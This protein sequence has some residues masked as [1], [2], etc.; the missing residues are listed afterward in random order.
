MYIGEEAA[1]SVLFAEGGR[2]SRDGLGGERRRKREPV[3]NE[4][5]KR[6]RKIFARGIA[7]FAPPIHTPGLELRC[8]EGGRNISVRGSVREGPKMQVARL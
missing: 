8:G 3:A 6:T 5:A 2:K 4:S 1:L 7:Q